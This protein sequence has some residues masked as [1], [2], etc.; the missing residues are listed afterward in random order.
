MSADPSKIPN[1][2]RLIA[3]LSA[4]DLLDTAVMF[5]RRGVALDETLPGKPPASAS[6]LLAVVPLPRLDLEGELRVGELIGE[7]GMGNV[8]LA[9]QRSLQRPVAVK[10]LREE[11]AG[12]A[13]AA[14][15][16]VDEARITGALEHPNITPIH[17]LGVDEHERPVMV[18]KKLSGRV[19]RD[20]MHESADAVG[21]TLVAASNVFG[22]NLEILMQ[23]CNAVE[24]AH[25]RGVVHRDIKPENVMV[26]DH[27]E[28]YLVDWGAAVDFR[29][30]EPSEAIVGTLAYMAPEMLRGS[31]P[32]VT[33]LTDV[34]LLGATLHEILTGKPPHACDDVQSA[35]FSICRSEVAP[36]PPYVAAELGD[37]CRRSLSRDPSERPQS[38]LAFK[39]ELSDFFVHRGSNELAHAATR[40]LSDLA[41]LCRAERAKTVVGN[42]EEAARVNQLFIECAFGYRQALEAWDANPEARAGLQEAHEHMIGFELENRNAKAAAAL[43]GQ[44]S[45]PREDFRQ[46]IEELKRELD[47]EARE[48]ARLRKIQKEQDASIASGARATSAAVTGVCLAGLFAW[49]SQRF[50]AAAGLDHRTIT[51]VT[52]IIMAGLA[53]GT[54]VS[55][56]KVL[57]NDVNRFLTA[58]MFAIVLTVVGIHIAGMLTGAPVTYALI[59]DFFVS[60]AVTA[61]VGASVHRGMISVGVAYLAGAVVASF[62]PHRVLEVMAVTFLVAQLAQAWTWRALARETAKRDV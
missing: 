31:G 38:A 39:R 3:E 43:L 17:A 36:F 34:Y 35:L 45:E 40:R 4:E 24:F 16:L 37:L 57:A 14:W 55:R 44:L 18:M 7:G 50:P 23:V 26:G 28:V 15:L 46:A 21:S 27:G 25:S 58:S 5:E 19:W 29:S 11:L 33:P 13:G 62:L 54:V 32:D 1:A 12:N 6:R 10:V 49:L 8:S 60:G 2:E 53:A 42:E 30:L 20:V 59:A 56:E 61:T 41:E 48:L 22:A 9:E 51:V 52:L 47:A